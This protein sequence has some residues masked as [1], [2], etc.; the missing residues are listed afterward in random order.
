MGAWETM[1]VWERGWSI[2]KLIPISIYL[3]YLKNSW[4]DLVS[5][6]IFVIFVFLEERDIKYKQKDLFTHVLTEVG[7]RD[8]MELNIG[9]QSVK[10]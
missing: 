1:R 2:W 9:G 8:Q 5:L 6:Y 3:V 4:F 7:N 10:Y